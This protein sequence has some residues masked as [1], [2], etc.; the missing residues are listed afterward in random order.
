[1]KEKIGFRE[2]LNMVLQLHRHSQTSQLMLS[3]F[4]QTEYIYT[5]FTDIKFS[6][7]SANRLVKLTC[8]PIHIKNINT[9]IGESIKSYL[10]F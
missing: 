5:H 8:K 10:V 1:M 4:D 6:S 9:K 2:N 3:L 7:L